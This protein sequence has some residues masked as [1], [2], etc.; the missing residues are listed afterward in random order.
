M[1]ERFAKGNEFVNKGLIASVG[2]FTFLE[3]KII[4]IELGFGEGAVPLTNLAW[5]IFPIL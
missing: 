3:Q 2:I 4:Q 5:R 1:R